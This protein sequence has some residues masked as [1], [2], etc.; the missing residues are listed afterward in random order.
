M[1]TKQEKAVEEHQAYQETCNHF[2]TWLRIA[3]EKLATC[4]DTFG[5][6]V[7][8]QDKMD[9]VCTLQGNMSD[10]QGLVNQVQAA[11]ERLLATTAKSGHP[12]I[13]RQVKITA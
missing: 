1:V 12:R 5:D 9:K 8:V 10:G 3:R 2:N 13:Q 4:S 11:S 7:T 6:K